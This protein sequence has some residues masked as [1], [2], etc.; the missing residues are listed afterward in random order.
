[1]TVRYSRTIN[2]SEVERHTEGTPHVQAIFDVAGHPLPPQ[3]RCS[4]LVQLCLRLD[5][6]PA[7]YQVEIDG[8]TYRAGYPH[9]LIKRPGSVHR[10]AAPGVCNAFCITYVA[11]D[12]PKE[13]Q[14]VVLTELAGSPELASALSRVRA[15]LGKTRE[16]GIADR[17]DS[18][19]AELILEI[20][21]AIARRREPSSAEDETIRQAVSYL[22]L[23]FMELVDY[24]DLARR[25][26]YSPRSFYRHWR[27]V[28]GNSPGDFVS[29]L[30]FAEA[31]RMLTETGY[32]LA[33][34]ALQLH[35]SEVSNFC[36][37]F[38]RRFG[39]TPRQCRMQQ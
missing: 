38:K 39:I 26:G 19:C 5:G 24:E 2:L 29:E 28:C 37:A 23:H 6:E 36:S 16:F 7:E 12:L 20:L 27:R 25:F 34:I 3:Q 11:E 8:V 13:L 33:V 10:H 32:S 31:K 1:M 30:R 9:L 18:R 35:Y 4:H 14:S 21:L 15:L 22:Q 17:L